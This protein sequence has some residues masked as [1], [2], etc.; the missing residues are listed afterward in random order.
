M[1]NDELDDVCGMTM[2]RGQTALYIHRKVALF[3]FLSATNNSSR[4]QSRIKEPATLD[5]REKP[6]SVPNYT[7]VRPTRRSADRRWFCRPFWTRHAGLKSGWGPTMS[8]QGLL[9][10][11]ELQFCCLPD[12]PQSVCRQTMKF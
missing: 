12:R 4:I 9:T 3:F 10:I 8:A 7:S 1:L 11:G 6:L 2:R 5:R